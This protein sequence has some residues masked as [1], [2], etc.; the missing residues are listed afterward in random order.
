MAKKSVNLRLERRRRVGEGKASGA[1]L[2]EK[3]TQNRERS[4]MMHECLY[5]DA[6]DDD[7]FV[8]NDE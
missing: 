1:L 4:K 8:N 2:P 5:S 6:A 7:C 3:T